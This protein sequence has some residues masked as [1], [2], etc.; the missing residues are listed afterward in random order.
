MW[1]YMYTTLGRR[2]LLTIKL[3]EQ[4]ENNFLPTFDLKYPISF[5]HPPQE[6]FIN[7]GITELS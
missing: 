4:L 7:S 2:F 3:D 6:K 1:P 5:L